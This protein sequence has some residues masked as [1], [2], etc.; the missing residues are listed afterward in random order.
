MIGQRVICVLGM[1]R[2]GTSSLTG[3]L[4]EAGVILG[5]VQ[6]KNLHN[7]KGNLENLK[8]MKL[9]DELLAA[10]GGTWDHPPEK[11]VWNDKYRRMRDSIIKEFEGNHLWTFK[12]P[13]TLYTLEGWLEALPGLTL[14]GTF[15]N[16]TAVA[17]SLNR[18]SG[19]PMKEGL[20]LWLKY[21][22]RLLAYHRQYLFQLISFD[23]HESEYRIA[24]TA[25]LTN[26]GLTVPASGFSFFSSDLRHIQIKE[27]AGL[28]REVTKVYQDLKAASGDFV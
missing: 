16:P 20:E 28:P 5:D 1:H 11:V 7:K 21:N 23:L 6:R 13:R 12:D 8:I 18:R 2:S 26:L 17:Q 22:R 10:N 27:D 3:S 19:M 14:V 9:H 25:L 24:I 15:R 4:E